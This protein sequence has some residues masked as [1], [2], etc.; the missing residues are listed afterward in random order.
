MDLTSPLLRMR[1][2]EVIARLIPHA[3]LKLYTNSS[4]FFL[5]EHFDQVV[6]DILEFLGTVKTAAAAWRNRVRSSFCAAAILRTECLL[7]VKS[8]HSAMSRRCPL[9]LQ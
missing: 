6:A 7:W 2:S 1:C 3:R 5:N 9:Y 8:G 4:H